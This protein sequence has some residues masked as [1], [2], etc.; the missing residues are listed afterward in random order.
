MTQDKP[1]R[2][3]VLARDLFAKHRTTFD[4]VLVVAVDLALCAGLRRHKQGAS[5]AYKF[6]DAPTW[7]KAL[8]E[9]LAP[10][11]ADAEQQGIDWARKGER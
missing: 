4:T 2:P 10:I 11:L 9:T 7:S 3:T 1:K 6:Y 5:E 8:A